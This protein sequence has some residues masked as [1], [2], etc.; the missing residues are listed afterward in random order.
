[1]IVAVCASLAVMPIQSGNLPDASA[2]LVAERPLL[3][4]LAIRRSRNRAVA[5]HNPADRVG[6]RRP[7]KPLSLRWAC[8]QRCHVRPASVDRS[9]LPFFPARQRFEPDGA[10]IKSAFPAVAFKAARSLVISTIRWQVGNFL[11]FASP[12]IELVPG[13]L[14]IGGASPVTVP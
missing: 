14:L 5:A 10:L 7:G 2:D 8:L 13:L 6:D 1:M 4:M 11:S 3:P 9:M 12:P